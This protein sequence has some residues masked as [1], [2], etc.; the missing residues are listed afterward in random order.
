M[1]NSAGTTLQNGKYLLNDVL[2][3]NAGGTTY[4]ATRCGSNHPVI[5]KSFNLPPETS[6][7]LA[8]D[9]F[10]QTFLHYA[11]TLSRFYHPN[12]VKVVGAFLQGGVPYLVLDYIP[13]QVL[14]TRL[15]HG[16]IPETE[17]VQWI[18]QA[19]F[20]LNALHRHGVFHLNLCPQN[21]LHRPSDPNIV[22][23]GLTPYAQTRWTLAAAAYAPPE[24]THLGTPTPLASE[25][26]FLAACLY[27][28]VTAQEPVPALDRDKRPLPAPR[29][30][31]PQLSETLEQAILR[32]MALDVRDRPPFLNEWLS[33]LPGA[34]LLQANTHAA[35]QPG[36]DP[37]LRELPPLQAPATAGS[38][39]SPAS[40]PKA[41]PEAIP[42]PSGPALN[43]THVTTSVD[44]PKAE[45]GSRLALVL[46]SLGAPVK[47]VATAPFVLTPRLD[48]FSSPPMAAEPQANT[49]VAPS[50]PMVPSSNLTAS[51]VSAPNAPDAKSASP[52]PPILDA[53]SVCPP[54][55]AAAVKPEGAAAPLVSTDSVPSLS[56][57]G[58]PES[59]ATSS[60]ISMT[61]APSL[62]S[63]QG[64]QRAI[65]KFP[66][67]TLFWCAV[68]AACGG[69]AGGLWL[70]WHIARQF[71]E[72]AQTEVPVRQVP[73]E[74]QF[75]PTSTSV[76]TP[77]KT[78]PVDPSDP[79][80]VGA[81]PEEVIP[82]VPTDGT[83]PPITNGVPYAEPRVGLS[84][85]PDSPGQPQTEA[86]GAQGVETYYEPVAPSYPAYPPDVPLY[87]DT[88]GQ[89]GQ[90]YDPNASP[91]EEIPVEDPALY[92]LDEAVP[93]S[94]ETG[95]AAGFDEFGDAF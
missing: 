63:S 60:T 8:V 10:R 73:Q 42:D 72:P 65:P 78:N 75:L 14:Q 41:N 88:L 16:P 4:R 35:L 31:R 34:A 9:Q 5:I 68:F 90:G 25:V 15:V 91:V 87:D 24:L 95:Q 28:L 2:S 80:A 89:Y 58:N 82:T 3:Q 93:V 29:R 44:P 64:F 81:Q 39:N 36:S 55:T 76:Q 37:S 11:K 17:A 52:E 94:P 43:V 83:E 18:R 69:L 77:K 70:R 66:K 74:E 33:L 40:A 62:R 12:L 56:S 51:E 86:Q 22:V 19:A 32:G 47:T 30:L 79:E 92:P 1:T 7:P 50:D 59:Q 48:Q 23:M 53:S 85:S 26:Y 46:P 6:D 49:P 67:W 84:S 45:L 57:T 20:A 38:P 21:L 54:N 71:L 61:S 27:A 13:G